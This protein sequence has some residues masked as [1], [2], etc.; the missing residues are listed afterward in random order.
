VDWNDARGWLNGRLQRIEQPLEKGQ[1]LLDEAVSTD[2]SHEE[3]R[4]YLAWLQARRGKRMAAARAFRELFQTCVSETNRGH[5]AVQLGLLHV[6]EGDH[7]A[8]LACFRW[9]R[10]SGLE[11]RDERFFVAGFNIAVQELALGRESAA[12]GS[13]RRLLDAHPARA[14]YLTELCAGSQTLQRSLEQRPGFAERLLGTCPELFAQ[15]APSSEGAERGAKAAAATL[16]FE[17]PFCEADGEALS[18]G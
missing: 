8:A 3:A 7:R 2:P 10:Q 5:A 15:A 16:E 9:V 17:S 14:E 18:E 13:L 11:R 6:E 12:L 4:I 1:R